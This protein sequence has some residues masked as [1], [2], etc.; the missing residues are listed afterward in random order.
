M[1]AQCADENRYR[2]TFAEILVIGSILQKLEGEE[3]DRFQRTRTETKE[4]KTTAKIKEYQ[5]LDTIADETY[6]GITGRLFQRQK[7][8]FRSMVFNMDQGKG[9]SAV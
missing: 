3:L 2:N 8:R 9:G 7:K 1:G 6:D 5:D 4:Q